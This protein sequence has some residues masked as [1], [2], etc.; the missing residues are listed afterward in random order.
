METG[1]HGVY[2]GVLWGTALE[3]VN[4]NSIRQEEKLNCSSANKCP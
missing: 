2:G 4:E 1:K 3:G